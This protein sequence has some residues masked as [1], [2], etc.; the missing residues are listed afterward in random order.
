MF[1][2]FPVILGCTLTDGKGL[3][4]QLSVSV[5]P[6]PVLQIE[7]NTSSQMGKG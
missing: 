2:S 6:W 1:V 5:L 3:D 4:H 7:G